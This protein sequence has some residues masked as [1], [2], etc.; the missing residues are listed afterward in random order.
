[1]EFEFDSRKSETN[2]K[3]HGIDFIEAQMLWDDPDRIEVPART[4]DEPRFLVVGK[5]SDK[6]YSGIITYR[7]EK[8]RIISVRLSR[9]EE[10]EMYE[11]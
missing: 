5:I 4:I 9:R 8:I 7:G 11:S 10:V 6:Y 1:M 2:K 3:K